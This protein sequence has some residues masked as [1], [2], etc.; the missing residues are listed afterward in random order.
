MASKLW[1]QVNEIKGRPHK[2]V[3]IGGKLS[4]DQINNFFHTM[5]I[6]SDHQPASEF[7]PDCDQHVA[8]FKFSTFVVSSVLSQLQTLDVRKATGPD[9]ISALF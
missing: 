5:A 2:L 7:I 3:S 6:S 8:Q 9:G 1:E 4:L